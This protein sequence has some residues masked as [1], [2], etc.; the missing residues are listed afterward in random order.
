M[1][2]R[3]AAIAIC[4]LLAALAWAPLGV[5]AWV[6]MPGSAGAT[7]TLLR[8]PV[9]IAKGG[10]NGPVV[11][12]DASASAGAGSPAPAPV[13]TRP[14]TVASSTPMAAPS[15][16]LAAALVKTPGVSKPA[17]SRAAA[18]AST[19][20]TPATIRSA[21]PGSSAAARPPV[22]SAPSAARRSTTAPMAGDL[23]VTWT[24]VVAVLTVLVVLGSMLLLFGR[25]QRQGGQ[26]VVAV[27][28]RR[29]P[30]SR[31]P[32]PSGAT[33]QPVTYD[34]RR[35]D[36]SPGSHD[37]ALPRRPSR[38]AP[39]DDPILRAMGLD[40]DAPASGGAR[41][42]RAQSRRVAQGPVARPR[43]GEPPP[44]EDERL[45]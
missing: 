12:P 27:D 4:S 6:A 38:L 45:P 22:A 16:S 9:V 33:G 39:S 42:V 29:S 5:F 28:D 30:G 10:A 13:A 41:A 19:R 1:T 8:P 32:L 18:G 20:P 3:R 14:A 26:R 40:P 37:P 36:R 34:R 17:P 44:N 11:A 31:H 23:P 2:R 24:W 35:T 7:S 15:A 21:G 43:P 25:G